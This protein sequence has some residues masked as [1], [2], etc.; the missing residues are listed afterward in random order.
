MMRLAPTRNSIEPAAVGGGLLLRMRAWFTTGGSADRRA[1]EEPHD[2]VSRKAPPAVIQDGNARTAVLL[3]FPI[4]GEALLV[5][6][7]GLLRVRIANRSLKQDPLLLDITRHSH[8]RMLIDRTAYVEFHAERATF[9][10]VVET[11]PD[12]TIRVETTDFDTVV[13]FVVQYIDERIADALA[14]EVAS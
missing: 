10:V 2:T 9:Y 4:R 5:K 6:L 3:P 8:A 7:A 11:M 12:T 14:P 13:K 1:Q